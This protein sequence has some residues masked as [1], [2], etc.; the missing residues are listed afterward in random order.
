MIYKTCFFFLALFM[1]F[2]V[3]QGQITIKQYTSATDTFYWKRYEH[4]KKPGKLSLSKYTVSRPGKVIDRFLS[5]NLYRFPQFSRDS[6]KPVRLADLKKCLYPMD[7]NGDQRTDMIFSG[8]SGGESGKTQI[9]I[10][11]QDSFELVFEDYQYVVSLVIQSGILTGLQMADIGCCDAYLY[12]TRDYRV[13]QQGC[14]LDFIKGKQTAVYH[15]TERPFDL[16]SPAIAWQAVYDTTLIRAS[17]ANLDDP[18]NPYME[19]WGNTIAGYINKIHGMA[20]A[21]KKDQYGKIW[22]Y[23]EIIP[24]IKPKKSI[25]YE[26]DKFPTFIQGW[27]EGSLIH[28]QP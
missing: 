18:Y 15:F 25:F 2:K 12:F 9:F 5:L 16:L 17:A 23:V 14:E 8:F 7:L 26:I 27:V 6:T 19:T 20:L 24:D 10:N 11:R 1:T 3:V 13:K 28:L 21:L 4:V 22:Y